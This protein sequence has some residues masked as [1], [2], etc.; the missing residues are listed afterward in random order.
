MASQFPPKKNTAYTFYVSLVSQAN[1]KIFQANPTLAAGDVKVAV[2]DAA[3]ANLGT[4]P[5]VDADF[6]KRVKVVMASG[7]MNGDNIS[8][9]FSDA[10]GAEWNDLTINLQ[11]TVSTWDE[12]KTALDTVATYVD[13]EVASIKTKTDQLTFTAANKVDAAFNAAGDFPQAAADKVWASGTRT[14]SS[15]GTL[16]D[17]I[18]DDACEGAETA[19]QLLRLFRAALVGKLSG[20][21][22]TT[23][24]MRDAADTKDRITATVDSDGNRTAITTDVS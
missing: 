6:T 4:L 10:A 12:E 1:A 7:E 14:L 2:D 13:T 21:A 22:T 18:W 15:F 20:A 8:I 17:D 3:P 5:V 23:V 19:R 16:V 11:T 24:V 9:I